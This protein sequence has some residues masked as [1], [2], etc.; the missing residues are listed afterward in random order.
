MAV[1][2]LVSAGVNTDSVAAASTVCNEDML[3]EVVLFDVLG[4]WCRV[5]AYLFGCPVLL[6]LEL[7]NT[8]LYR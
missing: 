7:E 6:A 5:E 1:M 2:S 8:V 4:R 3:A